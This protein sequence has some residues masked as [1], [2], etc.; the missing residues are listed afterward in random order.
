MDPM[1]NAQLKKI[2]AKLDRV[3]T[4]MA[5][6]RDIVRLEKRIDKL[7][8]KNEKRFD[9]IMTAIDGLTKAIEKFN[10]EYAALLQKRI[11]SNL[12]YG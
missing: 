4:A 9:Q 12:G 5:T 1:S 10:I 8:E 6:Q 11:A 7:E 3:I 2:D